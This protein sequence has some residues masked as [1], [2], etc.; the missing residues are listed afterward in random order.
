MI[1]EGFFMEKRRV[2]F[3]SDVKCYSAGDTAEQVQC[4]SLAVKAI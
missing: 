4:E 3:M 1:S 2:T